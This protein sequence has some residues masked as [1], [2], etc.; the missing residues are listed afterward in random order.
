MRAALIALCLAITSV[1]SASSIPE[2]DEANE[3]FRTHQ[4]ALAREKYNDLLYPPPPRLETKDQIVQAYVNLGVCRVIDGDIE[5]AKHEFEKALGLDPNWQLDPVMVTNKQAIQ[6][7]DDTKADLR[8][9]DR[10]RQQ[11]EELAK[12][13][14]AREALLKNTVIYEPHPFYLNFFPFGIGQ[15]QNGSTRKF[16][17]IGGGEFVAAATSISIWGYLVDKYGISN[18][19]LNV[20]RQTAQDI[21]TL[22]EVEVASAGVFFVI[23][24]V[25]VYDSLKHY[26]PRR[27]RKAEESD[28]PVEL[29]DL[30][31]QK[32]AK[33][34]KSSWLITPMITPNGAGI[35]VGWEN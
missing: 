6:L 5:G 15:L 7:F 4:Y 19:H 1:A 20:D 3:A 17:L 27:E 18:T 21:R 11:K 29:R 14:A 2:L 28:L 16:A 9:R 26:Q 24:G 34:K 31:K 13:Y 12:L 8:N 33:P 23:W 30:D 32:K 25:G 10:D 35:G 22:Q